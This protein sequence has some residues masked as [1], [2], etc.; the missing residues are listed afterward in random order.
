MIGDIVE[1]TRR[2]GTRLILIRLRFATIAPS[3]RALA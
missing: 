1:K 2:S 3:V